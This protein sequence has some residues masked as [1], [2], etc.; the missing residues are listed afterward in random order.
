MRLVR[1]LTVTVTVIIIIFVIPSCYKNEPSDQ[2][3]N[4]GNNE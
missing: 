4:S 3:T 1:F 2:S